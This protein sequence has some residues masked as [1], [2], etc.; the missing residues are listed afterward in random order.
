MEKEKLID[1]VC[2]M[3]KALICGLKTEIDCGLMN[4]DTKEAGEVADIIKDLSETEKN[5][6]EAKY[7]ELVTE[8]MEESDERYGYTPHVSGR[9]S[10]RYGYSKPIMD[11]KPYMDAY[12]RDPGQFRDDMRMGYIAHT[13][14][15]YGAE[16]DEYENAKKY[17]TKT[18]DAV[19]K[20]K[21]NTHGSIYF[22]ETIENA[23]DIWDN[24]D[25]TTKMK[26]KENL[27]ELVK[28][29]E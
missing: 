21:M 17:Y 14:N 23:K 29:F 22:A 18:G 11:Q 4:V 10:M 28:Y 9:S 24:A 25:A 6:K 2:C 15:A 20:D 16:Y 26:M 7:Y 13:D 5:L 8:A 27:K 3:Q 12:M 1:D 19:H